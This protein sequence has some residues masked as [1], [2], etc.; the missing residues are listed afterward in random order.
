MSIWHRG[1]K[2]RGPQGAEVCPG[3]PADDDLG[4]PARP[5]GGRKKEWLTLCS[6]CMDENRTRHSAQRIKYGWV[7][8]EVE[9]RWAD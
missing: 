3:L 7:F 6:D 4:F 8:D 5:C 2:Y 1:K 9:E